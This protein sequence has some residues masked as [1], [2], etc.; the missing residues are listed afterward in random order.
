MNR[1]LELTISVVTFKNGPDMLKRLFNSLL[2]TSLKIKILVIDNS[3]KNIIGELCKGPEFSY[4]FNKNNVGFGAGHNSIIRKI[5]GLSKYHLMINPDIYF[6][7]GVLEGIFDFMEDNPDVGL[8]MPKV[9]YPDGSI[10]HLCRL[11]PSPLDLLIR[12]L[13]IPL[14]TKKLDYFHAFE[15]T[16]YNETMDVPYLSGC[17]MFIRNEV[18]RKIG[19]F[20]ER[21]FMYMEDVDFSRRVNRYYRNVYYP[22][23]V[24]Y[25][26]YKK[27]SYNNFICFKRH[28]KSA[29]SYFNKWGWFWDQERRIINR[30]TIAKCLLT[31]KRLETN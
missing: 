17:F 28:I 26:E 18:F 4:I 6:N 24:I 8:A 9:L 25:H 7:R 5:I 23:A 31:R 19:I 14:I 3:D 27:D 20:D 10:Q 21:F 12:R 1:E 29:I 13:N 30:N 11:L 2:S 22:K 16:G 15:F